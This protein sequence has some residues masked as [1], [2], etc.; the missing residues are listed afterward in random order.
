[1]LLKVVGEAS[2]VIASGR[3][4]AALKLLAYQVPECFLYLAVCR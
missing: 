1:M 2:K 4:T 3:P